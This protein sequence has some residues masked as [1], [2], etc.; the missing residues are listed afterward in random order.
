[1][2][3]EELEKAIENE[4]TV[5]IVDNY[6]SD[7]LGATQIKLNKDYF[8][9]EENNTL[10]VEVDLYDDTDISIVGSFN[11]IYKTKAEAEWVAKMH[12][13]RVEVFEPPTWG[14]FIECKVIEFT[15]S[16][17]LYELKMCGEKVYLSYRT[18]IDDSVWDILFEEP[19]TKENYTKAVEYA[20]KLFEGVEDESIN[21]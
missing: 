15:I 7:I 1:M 4:E 19:A 16:K 14:K 12:T 6:L 10:C 18:F 5:Y 11:G 3:R 21:N 8:I 20:K 2:T 17:S 13:S 9:D